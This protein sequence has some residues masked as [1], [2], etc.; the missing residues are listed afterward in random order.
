MGLAQYLYDRWKERTVWPSKHDGDGRKVINSV[1]DEVL[2][3]RFSLACVM[4]K[5]GI[6][7][8]YMVGRG[9][10]CVCFWQGAV[11]VSVKSS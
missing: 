3:E 9:V 11:D 7:T 10:Q 1:C 5:E 4:G 8:L 6:S 2:K